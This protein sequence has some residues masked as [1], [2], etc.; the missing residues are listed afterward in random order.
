M[1]PKLANPTTSTEE[2]SSIPVTSSLYVVKDSN[3]AI[4]LDPKDYAETVRVVIEFLSVFPLHQALTAVPKTPISQ[5]LMKLAVDSFV[6]NDDNTITVNIQNDI[7]ATITKS[8]FLNAIRVPENPSNFTIFKPTKDEI[9]Q[10]KQEIGYIHPQKAKNKSDLVKSGCPAVWQVLIHLLLRSLSGKSGGTDCLNL[11][12][13]DFIY[14]IWSNRSNAV[15]VPQLLWDEFILYT[16]R[17]KNQEMPL[18]RFWALTLEAVYKEH[19]LN[20]TPDDGS[21]VCTFTNL[22]G[23]KCSDQTRFGTPKRL[24]KHM[25]DLLSPTSPYMNYHVAATEV[26]ARLSPTSDVDSAKKGEETSAQEGAST[27][28]KKKMACKKRKRGDLS[29]NPRSVKRKKCSDPPEN[30]SGSVLRTDFV[31]GKPPS[32]HASTAEGDA[33]K[34][35]AEQHTCI[36][37]RKTQS[38]GSF[39]PPKDS[40]LSSGTQGEIGFDKEIRHEESASVLYPEYV[41]ALQR[42]Y[43]D[44]SRSE[45]EEFVLM[46]KQR[47]F[48]GES[49]SVPNPIH[50]FTESDEHMSISSDS[51]EPAERIFE[52]DPKDQ[53]VID[54]ILQEPASLPGICKDNPDWNLGSESSSSD[55][56][57]LSSKKTSSSHEAC[58]SKDSVTKEEFNLLNGKVDQILG[59]LQQPTNFPCIEDRQKQLESL[60]ST[61]LQES[62]TQV[63][64]TYSIFEANCLLKVN[65]CLHEATANTKVFQ[66]TIDDLHR[67]HEK[68][69]SRLEDEIKEKDKQLI[70]QNEVLVRTLNTLSDLSDVLQLGRLTSAIEDAIQSILQKPTTADCLLRLSSAMRKKFDEVLSM[71]GDLNQSSVFARPV[72][73]GGNLG[74]NTDEEDEENN[75]EEE[76]EENIV[77]EEEEE[78]DEENIESEFQEMSPEKADP[79]HVVSKQ[80]AGGSLTWVPWSQVIDSVSHLDHVKESKMRY[81]QELKNFEE[82]EAKLSNVIVISPEKSLGSGENRDPLKEIPEKGEDEHSQPKVNQVQ[83]DDFDRVKDDHESAINQD[84]YPV[85]RWNPLAKIETYHMVPVE[86]YRVSESG[87]VQLDLPLSPFAMYYMRFPPAW[88]ELAED[89]QLHKERERL[90]IFFQKYAQPREKVW[91]LSA[92]RSV[93]NIRARSFQREKKNADFYSYDIR[94]RDETTTTISEADFPLMNPADMLIIGRHLDRLRETNLNMGPAYIAVCGFL[95]DYLCEFGR[96]DV[97]LYT[98]FK[99]TP[100][101]AGK[102]NNSKEIQDLPFGVVSTPELGFIYHTRNS[103]DR[104]YFKV[105]EKHLYPNSFLERAISKSIFMTGPTEVVRSIKDI[106]TWWVSVRS[107]MKRALVLASETCSRS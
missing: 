80:S 90:E 58:P 2:E 94:R 73:S 3:H 31:Q 18:E 27:V 74:E 103:T 12:W 67:R 70:I 42:K 19:N 59:L 62:V 24:P 105:S 78:N 1:A 82:Q 33:L 102:P 13:T 69:M 28:N 54:E 30:D 56:E 97:E 34:N 86:T 85:S 75:V 52:I 26:T 106:I 101:P 92:I 55:G 95:R 50:G 72:A 63:E 5:V 46:F 83:P 71:L 17:R 57:N 49:L 45:I 8:M 38:R 104:H 36:S 6:K 53:E 20:P 87:N 37:P 88:L 93:S 64:K 100:Q 79:E 84:L 81:C 14:S 48:R 10:F 29:V 99:D 44:R 65:E 66:Q 96:T 60:I 23:Y 7:K 15:D 40:K 16:S 98:F 41:A 32:G 11:L 43:P 107:W 4:S 68:R 35:V 61:R 51:S 22:K 76:E 91:S 89:V 39:T 25:L 21:L 77:E 47:Q 9:A